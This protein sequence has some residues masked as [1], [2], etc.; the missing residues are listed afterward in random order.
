MAGEVVFLSNQLYTSRRRAGFHELADAFVQGGWQ[1]TFVTTGLSWLSKLRRDRRLL[2][3]A[4]EDLNRTTVCADGVRSHIFMPLVHPVRTHPKLAALE[5]IAFASYGRRLSPD[6]EAALARAD[7]VIFESSAALMFFDRVRKIA[8]AAKTVYRVSDDLRVIPVSDVI[9]RQED[10]II[11]RFDLISLPSNIMLNGR[12]SAFPQA[13][14]HRHGIP[15]AI[16]DGVFQDPFPDRARP[17]MVSV[18]STLFDANFIHI[19]AKVRPDLDFHVIGDVGAASRVTLANIIYHGEL[20]FKQAAAYSAFCDVALAAYLPRIGS[21][22]LAETSN[23][24][25]QYTYF[26]KKIIAP[27]H[28]Q[29]RAGMAHIIPYDPDD[30][31]SI[32]AAYATAFEMDLATQPVQPPP[33]WTQ[34]RDM[35][36]DALN[37]PRGGGASERPRSTRLA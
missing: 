36:T 33:R 29:Q 35:I 32:A 15:G 22:Y 7:V 6:V 24:I 16:A 1:V 20:P 3:V 27:R 18:G 10:R 25:I 30:E 17:K 2:G 19:S 31:A 12:F 5:P 37:L 34:V 9:R 11:S 14:Y 8:P 13:R 28:I 23:K 26:G 21:E 4:Q